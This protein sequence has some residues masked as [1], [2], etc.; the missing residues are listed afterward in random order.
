MLKIMFMLFTAWATEKSLCFKLFCWCIKHLCSRSGFAESCIVSHV[1]PQASVYDDTG[2]YGSGQSSRAP[3]EY[4]WYS[5]GAS[6]TRSS[7]ASSSD[8]DTVSSVSQERFNR[9]RRDSASSDFSDISESAADYFSRS[10]RRGSIVSD[11]DEL[12]IPDLDAVS[13][14]TELKQ[15][16]WKCCG[17]I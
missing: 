10:N 13:D 8:D 11:L 6:S 2:L 1:C 17:S 4:S 12:S 7:P 15:C 5:S 14:R 9:G 3:S 16:A